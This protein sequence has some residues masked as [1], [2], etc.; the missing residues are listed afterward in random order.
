MALFYRLMLLSFLLLVSTCAQKQNQMNSKN[1][2]KVVS[3]SSSNL[4]SDDF[5]GR[6]VA[7]A[8]DRKNI[9]E[10]ILVTE[11]ARDS[12]LERNFNLLPL[13]GKL[14]T[15]PWTGD[16]WASYRGGISY[17]W[18]NRELDPDDSRRFEYEIGE[19]PGGDINRLSPA[20]KWD[21]YTGS[22]NFRLTRS[23]RRRVGL[24]ARKIPKWEGLCHSWAPATVNYKNPTTPVTVKSP[25]GQSITFYSS[26]IK[27]LLTYFLHWD[28]PR[29][30]GSGRSFSSFLGS[31]CEATLKE[32]REAYNNLMGWSPMTALRPYTK[33]L[34]GACGDSNAG[35]FHL[36][37]TNLLGKRKK[38]FMMD[39]TRTQEVW[40]QAVYKYESEVLET[41]DGASSGA[42]DGTVREKDILSKVWYVAEPSFPFSKDGIRSIDGKRIYTENTA[43]Q[44]KW[45]F[46]RVELDKSNKVI[47]GEWLKPKNYK[48]YFSGGL[49]P[50]DERFFEDRPDFLWDETSPDFYGRFTKLKGLYEA[51]IKKKTRPKFNEPKGDYL[52][53]LNTGILNVTNYYTKGNT[54]HLVGTSRYEQGGKLIVW[55]RTN[56][57]RTP[58]VVHRKKL[59]GKNFHVSFSLGRFGRFNTSIIAL[60]LKVNGKIVDSISYKGPDL[61]RL[62]R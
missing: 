7:S 25:Q 37:L 43:T 5:K 23:E 55:R 35:S 41:R 10:N 33:Y 54:I 51:S 61:A 34:K 20:E 16:Y 32:L 38:S 56:V 29:N 49:S 2:S 59:E 13:K 48:R 1:S 40:N 36:V 22:T 12:N 39:V 62:F 14:K 53:G 31:R 26:D 58:R 42:A 24:G 15:L 44:E 9:P 3:A 47:G 18:N 27:A 52:Y 46:Y 60:G 45:F 28:N 57:I 6:I 50:S 4:K 21:L 19:V 17:R 8:W 30:G 11:T